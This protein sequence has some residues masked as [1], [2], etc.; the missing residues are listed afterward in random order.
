MESP[1]AA[2][3]LDVLASLLPNLDRG[4][5]LTRVSRLASEDL[6]QTRASLFAGLE[7]RRNIGGLHG[8]SSS[9]GCASFLLVSRRR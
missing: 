4:Q 9:S 6:P 3:G 1:T 2:D 5:T 8:A 7:R